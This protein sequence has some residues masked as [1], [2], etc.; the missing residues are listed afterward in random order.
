MNDALHTE[1]LRTGRLRY[2]L[3][4]DGYE[5]TDQ[6][7]AV[8][9]S[10][11]RAMRESGFLRAFTSKLTLFTDGKD[12]AFDDAQRAHLD[13]LGVRSGFRD[14]PEPASHLAFRF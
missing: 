4:C 12:N 10:G 11:A 1:A 13:S 7:V 5:V 2:C 9:G 8:I 14:R 6:N 3:V